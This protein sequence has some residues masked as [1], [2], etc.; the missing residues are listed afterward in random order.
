MNHKE[1]ITC[2]SLS[3]KIFVMSLMEE[4][5]REIGL[6]SPTKRGHSFLGIKVI[7]EELMLLRQMYPSKKPLQRS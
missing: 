3:A 1:M 5:R 6:K 2:W 4:F 7:K